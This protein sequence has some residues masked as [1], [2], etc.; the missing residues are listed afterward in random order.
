[1]YNYIFLFYFNLYYHIKKHKIFIN[2][3]FII[4]EFNCKKKLKKIFLKILKKIMYP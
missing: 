3:Y 1:M 4:I 2:Y